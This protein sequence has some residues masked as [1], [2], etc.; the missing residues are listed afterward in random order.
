MKRNW[1]NVELERETAER[2]GAFLK[3]NGYKYE[4]SGCFNLV[5][6]E[7]YVDDEQVKA[8]DEWLQ[9]N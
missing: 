6:F 7:V 5:H 2:F 8:C 3:A 4:S 9:N 1:M